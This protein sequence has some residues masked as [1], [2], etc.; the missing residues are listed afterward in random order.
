MHSS[1]SSRPAAKPPG[2]STPAS[3]DA[4]AARR[5]CATAI[6]S[7]AARARRSRSA[8]AHAR[9]FIPRGP[10]SSPSSSSCSVHKGILGAFPTFADY[11]RRAGIVRTAHRHGDC[12]GRSGA[13]VGTLP[14]TT[15]A[16]RRDQRLVHHP[17]TGPTCD[18][19]F[20]TIEWTPVVPWAV[21]PFIGLVWWRSIM[22]AA[23][24]R[25]ARWCGSRCIPPACSRRPPSSVFWCG[26]RGRSLYLAAART[27]AG[28]H[29]VAV[30]R[31]QARDRRRAQRGRLVARRPH[32]GRFPHANVE[33]VNP[34]SPPASDR[35]VFC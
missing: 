28:H 8:S 35:Q 20:R 7:S 17:F 5:A 2:T 12:P 6:R 29:R 3:S 10:S 13:V 33:A 9:S 11:T 26:C 21:A 14:A 25:P 4:R 19:L 32:G 1:A 18:G 22:V 16:Q 31:R 15:L 30:R 27:D 23:G 24:S 34:A